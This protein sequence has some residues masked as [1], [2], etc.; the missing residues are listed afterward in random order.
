M[1]LSDTKDFASDSGHWYTKDGEPAYYQ[2]N[3]SKPGQMRPTTLRDAKKQG[4]LPSVTTICKVVAAPGLVNW[5]VEQAV[6]S[7]LTIPLKEGESEQDFLDRIRADAKEQ[8]AK[9]ADFGTRVHG[10][11][12]KHYLNE[13]YDPKL[14]LFVAGAVEEVEK[15]FPGGGWSAE[16]AFSCDEGYGG[17]VDLHRPWD[18]AMGGV[19]IDFKGKDGDLSDV[20]CYDEHHMQAAAYQVGLYGP[21]GNITTA[22]C[23]FS[24][25]HPGVAKMVIHTEKE[26]LRGWRMFR[27]AKE[28]WCAQ[29]DYY[30][31]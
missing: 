27:A 13:V 1:N 12:E 30:P 10:A 4:L 14:A 15:H 6:L 2:P 19:L 7:A 8:G 16:K 9:A 28:L 31:S 21:V 26:I 29:K 18:E 17:K 24:R 22:N 11:I 25:T 5:M 3:A 23:F 20:E